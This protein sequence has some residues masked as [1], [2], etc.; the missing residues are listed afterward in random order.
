MAHRYDFPAAVS[1]IKTE[2]KAGHTFARVALSSRFP[3]KTARN[4]AHAQKAYD[5]ARQWTQETELSPDDSIE[6]ADQL[7]R[8]KTQ[9]EELRKRSKPAR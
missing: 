7:E 2:I 3:I 5:T 4:T 8:L 9:L 6:I 1:A